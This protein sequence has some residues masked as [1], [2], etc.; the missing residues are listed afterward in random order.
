MCYAQTNTGPLKSLEH[1]CSTSYVMGAT[2]KKIHLRQASI[3]FNT[4]NEDLERCTYKQMYNFTY[5]F[6][7]YTT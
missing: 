5:V 4:K 1:A 6:F 3:K 2:S 7:I